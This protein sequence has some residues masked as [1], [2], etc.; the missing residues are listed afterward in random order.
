MRRL[1]QTALGFACGT[2]RGIFIGTPWPPRPLFMNCK[3]L[4]AGSPELDIATHVFALD[5][6]HAV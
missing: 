4:A 5:G 1:A 2:A 6:A 3:I